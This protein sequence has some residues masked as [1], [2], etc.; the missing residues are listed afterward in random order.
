MS[1]TDN[2]WV[3]P[4]SAHFQHTS[5]GVMNT[6]QIFAPNWKSFPRYGP[7]K[8]IG[9]TGRWGGGRT[10]TLLKWCLEFKHTQNKRI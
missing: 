5:M 4:M 3:H 1:V 7:L 8:N 6:E 2:L 10:Y 9:V